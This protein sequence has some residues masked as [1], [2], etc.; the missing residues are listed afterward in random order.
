MCATLVSKSTRSSSSAGRGAPS[1]SL[2][3]TA[4]FRSASPDPSC[5]DRP[6]SV[7]LGDDP[8]EPPPFASSE[9]TRLRRAP[10]R[11]LALGDDPLEPPPFASSEGTRLRRAPPRSL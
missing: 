3:I 1:H 5:S 11:S 10:P 8:L 7:S 2:A 9:G 6:Y 4:A